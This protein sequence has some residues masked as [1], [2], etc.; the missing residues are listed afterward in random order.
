MSSAN[1]IWTVL[2]QF[3]LAGFVL[4]FVFPILHGLATAI[5]GAVLMVKENRK[6]GKLCIPALIILIRGAFTIVSTLLYYF[7][8]RTVIS[9][10]FSQYSK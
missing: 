10:M 1:D 8:N 5:L 7:G 6:N 9:E 2:F 4:F 3:I